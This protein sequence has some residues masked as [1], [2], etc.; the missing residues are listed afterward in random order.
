MRITNKQESKQ[1]IP[2]IRFKR[3]PT[4]LGLL[5]SYFRGV[6]PSVGSGLYSRL[7]P[8]ADKFD[9]GAVKTI[10]TLM[11]GTASA[12]VA[13][14]DLVKEIIKLVP[15]VTPLTMIVILQLCGYNSA[16]LFGEHVLPMITATINEIAPLLKELLTELLVP[17]HYQ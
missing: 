10:S 2:R 17:K 11:R 4:L 3:T 13:T 8:L 12:S 1:T 16:E 6:A 15:N 14:V 7:N 9:E 5:V